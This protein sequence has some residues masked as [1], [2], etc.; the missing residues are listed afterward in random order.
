M[1]CSVMSER[2]FGVFSL[3]FFVFKF[4]VHVLSTLYTYYP[5]NVKKSYENVDSFCYCTEINID[6]KKMYSK[7]TNM[8]SMRSSGVGNCLFL[9]ALGWGTDKRKKFQIPGGIPGG[10]HGNRSD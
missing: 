1:K 3:R 9:R 5:S 10:G 2:P 7:N 8:R 4:I 6:L